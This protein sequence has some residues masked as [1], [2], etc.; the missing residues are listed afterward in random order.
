VCFSADADLVSGLVV[1]AIGID[2]LRHVRRPAQLPLAILPVILGGHQL[3]EALVWWGLEGRV[4]H[5]VWHPAL[6]LY[7]TVAFGVLPVLIPIAVG[8]L[9]LIANRLRV[10]LLTATGIIVAGVLMYAVARGPVQARIEGHH[11]A[12]NVALWRGGLIVAL[13]V[14]VTCGSLLLSK[15]RY[16]R[17]FGVVN[18]VAVCLLVWLN[19]SGFI[20]LWCAWAAITS[21]AIAV[22][23]RFVSPPA[24]QLRPGPDPQQGRRARDQRATGDTATP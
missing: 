14:L 15:V 10:G 2:T 17:Q 16:V 12:Y 24:G 23:L 4:A 1:G 20:S 18:L 11:I 7:L 3:V 5:A 6:V 9:E 13:Y 22:H 21:G 8:A 19:Q